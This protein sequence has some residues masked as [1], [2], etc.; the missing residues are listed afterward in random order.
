MP[1]FE[2]GWIDTVRGTI[3]IDDC[4]VNGHLNVKSYFGIFCD[5]SDYLTSHLGI[6]Y[7]DL[8]SEGRGLVSIVNTIRYLDELHDGD[9]YV[10]QSAVVRLGGTSIRYVSRLMNVATGS[11]SA[12]SDL[13]EAHFNLETRKTQ[14]WSDGDRARIGAMVLTL[15]DEDLAWYAG[16]R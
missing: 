13:T 7:S 10:V 16:G 9:R 5:A 12:T 3:N 2:E 15:S 11:I 4:D 8:A 1:E 6:Y 14:P